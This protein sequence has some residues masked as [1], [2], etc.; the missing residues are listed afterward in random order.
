LATQPSHFSLIIEKLNAHQLVQNSKVVIEKPF[1][2]DLESAVDLQKNISKY[3]EESQI[4]LMDHYLGKEGVQNL[5]SFRFENKLLEPFWNHQ[6]ID[7]VQI[8]LSEEMGIGTR[9]H[10][11]EETGYLRDVFQNH[12]MQLLALLAMEPP[13]DQKI[14]S[15]QTEKIKVLNAVRPFPVEG[16]D[17]Y[18]VRGQYGPGKLHGLEVLGY[19]QESGVPKTSPVETFLTAKLF[20]DNPR[21][22]GVPFYVRGGKRL[23]VQTTEIAIVFKKDPSKEQA[24]KTLFIRIQPNAGI[25]LE[26]ESKASSGNAVQQVLLA[27]SQKTSQEAYE[28]LIYDCIRGDKSLFVRT[29]EQLAAWRLFTPVIKHWKTH[30]PETFPNY[31]AGTWGPSS[32]DPLLKQNGHQWRLLENSK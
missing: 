20:I 2:Y 25:F 5:L 18:I 26:T 15:I 24:S 8:T 21:W 12:L 23:P 22:Q 3:L 11:W 31:E 4:Y 17:K 32:V 6:H 7:H 13:L 16:I 1:G 28:K 30:P 10:F 9:A 14:E 19:N 27:S 29:E